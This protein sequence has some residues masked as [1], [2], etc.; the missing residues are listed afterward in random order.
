VGKGSGKREFSRGGS[1]PVG[2]RESKPQGFEEEGRCLTDDG[3]CPAPG[4]TKERQNFLVV[5]CM[6]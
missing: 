1:L 2:G 4:A 5:F 3:W 6:R